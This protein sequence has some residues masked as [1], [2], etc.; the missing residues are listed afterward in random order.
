MSDI[1]ELDSGLFPDRATLGAAVEALEIP[2][3]RV[4]L[5]AARTAEDWDAV[6]AALMKARIVLS[7]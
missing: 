5:R 3:R 6:V 2:V 4:D 1:L 7:V